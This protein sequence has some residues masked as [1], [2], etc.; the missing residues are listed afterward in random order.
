MLAK[1]SLAELFLKLKQKISSLRSFQMHAWYTSN[2]IHA[3]GILV[4]SS[5]QSFGRVLWE[6][7]GCGALFVLKVQYARI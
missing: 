6:Y 4:L 5:M 3:A 7:P 1:S 2:D